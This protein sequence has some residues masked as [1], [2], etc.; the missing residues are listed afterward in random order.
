VA[1][2]G[3]TLFLRAKLV[4]ASGWRKEEAAPFPQKLVFT[5]NGWTTSGPKKGVVR[6]LRRTG[7]VVKLAAI[8]TGIHAVAE[9]RI[10]SA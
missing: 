8:G 3:T 4:F 9:I 7:S 10:S 1:G 6:R 5:G 2:F